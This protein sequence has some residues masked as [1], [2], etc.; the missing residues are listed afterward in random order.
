MENH[1]VKSSEEIVQELGI[2]AFSSVSDYVTWDKSGQMKLK[3][4]IPL[5]KMQALKELSVG[6]NGI[7]RTIKMHDKVEALAKLSDYGV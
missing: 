1:S 6:E 4:D 5:E 2:I 7:V 3:K